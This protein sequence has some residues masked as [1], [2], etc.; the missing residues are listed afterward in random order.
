MSSIR[1]ALAAA[2]MITAV[3]AAGLITA[4]AAPAAAAPVNSA[5]HCVHN[6]GTQRTDCFAT[7]PEAVSFATGGL[8]TNAPDSPAAAA[9]D[10]SFE[11]RINAIGALAE[12]DDVSPLAVT[13]SVEFDWAYHQDNVGSITYTASSGCANYYWFKNYVGDG[14]N[15]RISSFRGYNSCEANHYENADLGGT[16]TGFLATASV[17]SN[18]MNNE[19]SSIAWR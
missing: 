10:E 14:W 12:A 6:L 16:S 11:K 17:M 1:K 19:T 5:G 9:A 2:G 18:G 4:T 8:L 13:L 3:T 15:D 7:F